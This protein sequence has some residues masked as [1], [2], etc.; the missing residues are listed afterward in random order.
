MKK[1]KKKK[2]KKRKRK[3]KRNW[4]V[5]PGVSCPVPVFSRQI[6]VQ[7]ARCQLPNWRTEKFRFRK[8]AFVFVEAVFCCFFLTSLLIFLNPSVLKIGT[9]KKKKKKKKKKMCAPRKSDQMLEDSCKG[10]FL[11]LVT[12]N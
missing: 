9:L 7:I 3:K 11:I 4:C 8:S 1:T 10:L 12:P 5:R 2:K 6:A